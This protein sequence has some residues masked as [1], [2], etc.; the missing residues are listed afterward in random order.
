MLVIFQYKAVL[1]CL[2]SVTGM[3]R[4]IF[5]LLN[6]MAV[7][8]VY[9]CLYYAHGFLRATHLI[10]ACS[11]LFLYITNPLCRKLFSPA[12]ILYFSTFIKF[13]EEIF[14]FPLRSKVSMK[15]SFDLELFVQY[16]LYL[17]PA[18]ENNHCSTLETP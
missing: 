4:S 13:N 17:F 18:L 7:K 11:R 15:L 14:Q 2:F 8:Y 5:I 9:Q 12:D 6:V 3:A 16:G 10:P 1:L